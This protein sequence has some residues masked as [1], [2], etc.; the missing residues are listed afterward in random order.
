MGVIVVRLADRRV[1]EGQQTT[2]TINRLPAPIDFVVSV[3]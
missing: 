3:R 2:M 1:A